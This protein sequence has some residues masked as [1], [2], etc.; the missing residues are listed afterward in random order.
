[1]D[2]LDELT[3]LTHCDTMS[4]QQVGTIDV[5]HP[6]PIGE[7]I[8]ISQRNN[9]RPPSFDFSLESNDQTQS[10]LFLCKV[11]LEAKFQTFEEVGAGRAKKTAKRIAALKLLA[12]LKRHSASVNDTSY[13]SSSCKSSPSIQTKSTISQQN[14]EE[15][16]FVEQPPTR[17]VSNG[18]KIEKSPSDL[19]SVSLLNLNPK[20]KILNTFNQ[21][22]NSSKPTIRKLLNDF[23]LK[24]THLNKS[25]FDALTSEENLKFE[26]YQL[27]K[28]DGNETKKN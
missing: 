25:F 8:E 23:T 13:N 6:N 4:D 20:E 26:I 2:E 18:V 14:R 3:E 5:G 11:T 24:K 10:A 9:L 19:T 21:L 7:L 22:K 15:L 16:D 1:M 27:A 28:N 12:K 17:P